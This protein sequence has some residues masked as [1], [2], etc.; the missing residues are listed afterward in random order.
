MGIIPVHRLVWLGILILFLRR[1]PAVFALYRFIRQIEDIRQ[2]M[3]VGFFGPIGVSAVFY[4][5]V[6]QEFLKTIDGSQQPHA[7]RLGETLKIV[8][9]FL[10]I[11]SIVSLAQCNLILLHRTY[12]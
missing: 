10:V 6:S 3:F 11:F 8:V 9:W 2:A 5:Y 7:Q 4:I 12:I 1:V